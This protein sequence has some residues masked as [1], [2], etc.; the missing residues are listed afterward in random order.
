MGRNSTG[1]K[2]FLDPSH[3]LGMTGLEPVT[4]APPLALLRACF[5]LFA[6]DTVSADLSS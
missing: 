2:S 3:S 4:L 5:A 6:R 1:E